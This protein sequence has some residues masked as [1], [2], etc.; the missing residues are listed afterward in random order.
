MYIIVSYAVYLMVTL[1]VTV[2]TARKL[3]SS[4]RIF[5]V[6]TFQ[7]NQALADSVNRL[8]MVGFYLVNVGFIAMALETGI[9]TVNAYAIEV[10]SGKI[11]A[12][13]LAP[14]CMQ[15]VCLFLF[16]LIRRRNG[17]LGQRV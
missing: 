2:W 10:V 1:A 9:H 16:S 12:F 11:G 8:L 15:F 13:L 7:G 17:P 14:G 5:M 6:D 4:G 3:H